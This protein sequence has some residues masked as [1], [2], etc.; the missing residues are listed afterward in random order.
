MYDRAMTSLLVATTCAIVFCGC[1]GQRGGGSAGPDR[2]GPGGDILRVGNGAEPEGLDP[3]VVTGVPEHHILLTLFEGLVRM[4]PKTLA[5]TPGVAETWEVSPDGLVY[6]FHLRKGGKW[7]NGDPLTSK[8]FAY[9][10]RRCLTPSLAAEYAYMLFPMKNAKAYNDGTITDFAQVGCE[11]PDDYTVQVTLENPTPYFYSLQCH[12]TWFPVHQKSI[13][14]SGPMDDRGSKWTRPGSLVGNGP[15][16]LTR[17]APNDVIE[18]RPNSNYW[19][20]AGVKNGGV[21][22]YPVNEEQTE[23]RMFRAGE[24]DVTENVPPAKVLDYRKNRPEVLRTDDWIGAYF[25]RVNTKRKPL[26]DKRVRQALAM[27]IDRE[28]ICSKI[29]TAGEKAAYFLT[30]PGTAGYTSTARLPFDPARARQLL[31]EAGY[32]GGKGFPKIDILYNTL[33]R[34]QTIAEAVQQMWKTNLGVDITLRN[35][36]WKVYLNST[37]NEQMDFDLARAGWIGDVVD[38]MNFL[39]CFITGNGNNRTGWGNAE[40]DRLLAEA[41]KQND[42]TKRYALYD[43]AERILMDEVPILPVYHYVRPYLIQPDVRGYEPNI[44]AYYA[45]H[46]VWFDKGAK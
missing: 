17:W 39:E 35:E 45:Y 40:Y 33:E 16:L 20:A 14:A 6:T 42:M 34:H 9:A 21:D 3:H 27:S 46:K 32:P 26:D 11:F 22:F 23:E 43:Q 8:D 29:M 15:Y 28:A 1:S 25:Y 2:S 5:P 13:E 38:P 41:I 31:A 10:W 37:S 18:V 44:L 19:D 7:S 12:Y 36:E 4:D 24:L 30:P